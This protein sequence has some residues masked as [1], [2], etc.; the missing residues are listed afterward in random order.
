MN[1]KIRLKEIMKERRVSLSAFA[2]KM[3]VTSNGVAVNGNFNPT[4]GKLEQYADALGVPVWE[5]FVDCGKLPEVKV[6]EKSDS[7]VL[8]C[9]NCG[10]EIEIEMKLKAKK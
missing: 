4:I 3:G 8:S 10:A 7:A 2:E 9:P 5:L 6:V 1:T